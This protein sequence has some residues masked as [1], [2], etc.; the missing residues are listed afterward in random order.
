MINEYNQVFW[1]WYSMIFNMNI[2]R[3][4][5]SFAMRSLLC[6][7]D[8]QSYTFCLLLLLYTYQIFDLSQ[9]LNAYNMHM[10]A[11]KNLNQSSKYM[12]CFFTLN[13]VYLYLFLVNSMIDSLTYI[14][15]FLFHSY[16]YCEFF[17]F[18]VLDSDKHL[19]FIS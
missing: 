8:S 14:F 12:H 16:S 5:G 19:S 18:F 2:I 4:F 15:P 10:D 17:V 9:H 11:L 3:H 7:P 1:L 13:D 6:A